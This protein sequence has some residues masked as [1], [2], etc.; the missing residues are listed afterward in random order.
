MIRI[1]LLPFRAARK[2]ENIRREVSIFILLIIFLVLGLSY[3][4]IHLDKK[5]TSLDNQIKTV[6]RGINKYKEKANRVN[7]IKKAIR[8]YQKKVNIIKSLKN[9]RREIVILLDS[10]TSL[11]I[12]EKMWLR[13]LQINENGVIITGTAFDQKTV[14]EFMT[15]LQTSPFFTKNVKLN[16]LSM[17]TVANGIVV[18]NFVLNCKRTTVLNKTK[19]KLKK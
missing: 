12:P 8:V 11:I 4:G 3:Y 7:K 14:A 2:R 18:Q 19:K 5:I 17:K 10:M 6:E 13:N 15:N 9:R 1:N 16:N